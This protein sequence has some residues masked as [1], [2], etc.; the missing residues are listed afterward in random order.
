MHH[1]GSTNGGGRLKRFGFVIQAKSAAAME[2]YK[3]LH[4]NVPEEISGPDGALAAIGL[5]RMSI[6]CWPPYTLFMLVE[7]DENFDPARDFG[8]ALKMHPAVQ[9]WD[10]V[11]HGPDPL[12]QPVAGNDTDLQWFRL[13][14]A[15][16]WDVPPG[17]ERASLTEDENVEA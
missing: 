3:E 6:L 10:D 1:V 9:A 4:K 16:A 12:L 13:E 15:Y 8:R 5:H 7:A 11:M 17:S 2:R 14:E